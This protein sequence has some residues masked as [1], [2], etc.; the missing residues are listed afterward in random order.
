M[1]LNDFCNNL[2]MILS[3][4]CNY[5]SFFLIYFV[6]FS[7]VIIMW[8]MFFRFL[9]RLWENFSCYSGSTLE[10]YDEVGICV[11]GNPYLMCE[12]CPYSVY[13]VIG[14][15]GDR[16]FCTLNDTY[17]DQSIYNRSEREKEK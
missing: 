9:R 15:Y 10:P 2:Q 1:I 12:S 6:L 5:F 8:K 7:I 13:E 11:Y 3:D 14:I 4:I 16:I 17:V